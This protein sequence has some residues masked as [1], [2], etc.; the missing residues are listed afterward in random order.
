MEDGANAPRSR[1]LVTSSRRLS[2]SR[3]RMGTGASAAGQSFSARAPRSGTGS[4][5]R[6][7]GESSETELQMPGAFDEE[8]SGSRGGS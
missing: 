4:G 8:V 6:E 3:R 1:R 2:V 7:L 5:E